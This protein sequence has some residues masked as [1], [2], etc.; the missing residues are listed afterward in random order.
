M[1]TS[2]RDYYDI[3]EI[4]KGSSEEEIKKAFRKLALKYHPD[5]NKASGAEGKFKEINE[6]YQ[7]LSDTEKRQI[8]D[9]FGHD[10]VS[11]SRSAKGFDG[12]ENFGGVGDIFDAFFGGGG[13]N[14]SNRQQVHQ[15]SDLQTAIT[16]NFEESV[17]GTESEIQIQR[18][19]KCFHC[20]GNKNE[21]GTD[22]P[23]CTPCN[24]SGQVRR[25]QQSVFGQFVQVGNCSTCNGRGK[26]INTPCSECSGNGRTRKKRKLSV[27]IP[28]GIETDTQIRLT[29]EGEASIDGGPPGDL[30]LHISVTPHEYFNRKKY[31]IHSIRNINISQA[32]LGDKIR[33]QTLEG[34]IELTIPK[35]TQNGR[36]FRLKGQGIVHLNSNKRGD[37]IVSITVKTPEDLT[38][39]QEEILKELSNTLEDPDNELNTNAKSWFSKIKD[40]INKED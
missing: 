16:I 2:K 17:F 34:E 24:G 37:H 21:P 15:G 35:G 13:G 22:T 1:T 30:F 10:A 19:E 11:G 26:I 39:S 18:I 9:K 27:A 4:P 20:K 14:T 6:A 12:F 29:G 5:R 32:A 33:V 25:S 23:R 36:N 38:N 8:Y 7:V 28:A 31:D 40:S 3:L